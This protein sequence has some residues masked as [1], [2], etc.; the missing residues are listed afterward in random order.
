MFHNRIRKIA[1][2]AASLKFPAIRV[3]RVSAPMS[4]VVENDGNAP[5]NF[6]SI[7]PVS[8]SQVDAA[9]TVCSTSSALAPLDTCVTGVDFAPTVTGDP[10]TGSLALNSDAGNGPGIISPYGTVLDIDPTTLALSSSANPSQTGATVTFTVTATSAGTTPTGT[11]TFSD[12]FGQT[13]TTL[14]TVTMANGSASLPVAMLVAGQHLITAAYSGDSSNAAATTTP[15]T[16]VIKDAQPPTMASL[17]SSANPIDGGASLTLTATV[18]T[19]TQGAGSYAIAGTVTLM[20][21]STTLGTVQL[22]AATATLDH[23]TATFATDKLSIG[24]HSLTAVYAGNANDQAS[25]SPVLTQVVKLAT[26]TLSLA[27]SANPLASGAP[28]ALTATATSTGG[29][30]TGAV[31]F[32]VGGTLLG[33]AN[34]NGQ[35]AAVLQLPSAEWLPGTYSLTATY[36]GD[37]ADSNAASPPVSEV[38]HLANANVTLAS[39]LNP[40]GIG[41]QVLFTATAGSNGGTPTGSITF[42]DGGVMLGSAALNASGI[43]SF[44]TSALA[45]GSHAI[46][47]AYA[48]DS[49]DGV[50]S[51]APLS[52]VVQAATIGI[53]LA[54]SKSPAIFAETVTLTAV[55]TGT[56]SSP[57]GS[58]AFFDGAT[59]LGDVKIDASG[60]AVYTTSSL[61]IGD[62]ALSAMYSGD[63]NHSAVTS[64]PVD[65]QVLQATALLLQASTNHTIAGL[66]VTLHGVV[67]GTSNQPGAPQPTGTIAI[68]DGTATLSTLTPDASGNVSYTAMLAVGQHTLGAAYAGDRN[69]APS[70]APS[71]AVQVDLATTTT[72]LTVS[73]SPA[74]FGAPVTLTASVAG[75]GGV[76]S[77]TVILM[78]GT[79][80]L[81]RVPLLA[82]GSATLTLTTLA[83]GIHA[84]TAVYAG[85]ANDQGSQSPAVQEQVAL[86]TT[87]SITASANPALLGDKRGADADLSER[88]RHG[89]HRPR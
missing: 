71:I 72:S 38:L 31:S 23:A 79:A 88:L 4:Q 59:H 22:A 36:A 33:V 30:P 89:S 76:P 78:D 87:L 49:Y 25:S 73:P 65:E 27:T 47:A 80:T 3:G 10:V 66:P 29:T 40:A 7:A 85:D 53:A 32:F 64:S 24:S 2:N 18:A 55:V 54:T 75:N 12:A 83:P 60:H 43:A 56:G 67:S 41:A 19:K 15:L 16:E 62:H 74:A 84:L 13:T 37:A 17:T 50:A 45:I 69:D 1:A 8:N 11:I 20:D 77:G 44:S 63:V 26:A 61:T 48:G 9:S 86:H 14:G 6:S 81:S 28:L 70:S 58:V 51:S 42:A 68:S 35:G 52:E 57:V 34:L 21:G 39:S 46:T 82:N 5:L